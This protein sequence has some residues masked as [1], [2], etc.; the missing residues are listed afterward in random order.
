MQVQRKIPKGQKIELDEIF[1]SIKN[2]PMNREQ[3]RKMPKN[4]SNP[5]EFKD[6]INGPATVIVPIAIY[7]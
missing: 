4:I 6:V 7:Q 1:E 3:K 2:I 5:K